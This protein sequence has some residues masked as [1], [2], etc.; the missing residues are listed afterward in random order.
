MPST[1]QELQKGGHQPKQEAPHQAMPT[2]GEAG[3]TPDPRGAPSLTVL[4]VRALLSIALTTKLFLRVD[5]K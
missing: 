3:V 1:Q 2:R 5:I 4:K